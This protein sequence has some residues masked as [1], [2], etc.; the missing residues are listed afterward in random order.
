MLYWRAIMNGVTVKRG[1]AGLGLFAEQE[2]KRSDFIIEYIGEKLTPE[3][4][5]KRGGRYLFTVDKTC[6]IDGKGRENQA[7]YINHSCV[8]NAYAEADVDEKRV[9]FY[10]KKRIQPGEEITCHYGKQYFDDLINEHC[11]CPVCNQE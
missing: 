6:V 10:A 3:E 7:R 11:R 5:D 8:P 9:R 2:F 1:L 4:A